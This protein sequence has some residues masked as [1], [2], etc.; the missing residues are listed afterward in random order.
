MSHLTTLTSTQSSWFLE[1]TDV[2]LGSSFCTF[3]P[4]GGN[5]FVLVEAPIVLTYF[6]SLYLL[7]APSQKIILP[8]QPVRVLDYKRKPKNQNP[9]LK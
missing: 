1:R 3:Q 9:T 4:S 7:K 6:S 5:P 2:S 8:G